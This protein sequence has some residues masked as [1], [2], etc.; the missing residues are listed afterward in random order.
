MQAS[1]R[2]ARFALIALAAS[3][4]YAPSN[5]Q[6]RER[7]SGEAEAALFAEACATC[8]TAAGED[9]TPG[10]MMLRALSPRAIVASLE[11]GVM[12]AEGA[13]LTP[14][15]RVRLAE[16]LTGR[17]FTREILP[18][19]AFCADRGW[20]ALDLGA[21]SSM[22]WGGNLEATG[23]QAAEMAG[24]SADDVPN[25]ELKWAFAFPD[26]AEVRTKPT[27]IGDAVLVGGPFGEVLALDA[28]TGCVRWSFEA[29][30]A[31]RGAVV[32]GEGPEGRPT[33]Y[34]VDFRTNAYAL[35]AATGDLLWKYHVGW[36]STSNTTG[37]PAFHDGRLFVPISSWEVVVS[38]DPA[39]ECCTASGAVA[40]LDAVTGDVLWYH[41]VIP[42][43]PAEAGTSEAGTQLWA[44]SGAPVWSSPT[45]DAARGLVYAGTGENYTRPTTDN[46]DAIIAID[47]ETGEL[48]WSFQATPE[49]AFTMACTSATARQNCPDPPGPDLDFGMAPMLV[50]RPDGKEILVA[51]QKSG[52]VW[53]LDPDDGGAL[54]WSTRVGK[55]SALGGIHWGMASDGRYAYAPVADRDA[56]IVDV[57]P[58]DEPSP[59]MYALDL[60][61]GEVV[62]SVPAAT[63][64][65]EGKRGCY[66]ALSS[67]PAAIPGVVFSGG[68]D[69][70]I[71]AY[72]AG[73]GRILW[74]FD[75]TEVTETSNGVPGRGGSIDGPGPVIAGGMLFTNSGYSTF[76]QM[77]GNLLL[78]FGV[79]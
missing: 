47:I 56:V 12:Q 38:G 65:C 32:A 27:V 19:S 78:A 31:V 13:D 6:E 22:G 28:A 9:R 34:F 58:D 11:D 3:V 75:T 35:D 45:I 57:N 44:P 5:A 36:H 74:D 26:A 68:L 46:S 8:H 24:L 53:A 62:W 48:A 25:L 33:A 10:V 41:R 29:D 49:D 37:S 52:V 2:S 30:A 18:E 70:H 43:Y 4:S 42:G 54:L 16:Y 39:Y 72:A 50:T 59:G 77:P 64:T 73:G 67:A 40:A 61:T 15:Q 7:R 79:R 17:A 69:G 21:V 63:D 71:R 51:G 1:T 23:F 14:E 66:A 55:G 76:G 20:S 60:M